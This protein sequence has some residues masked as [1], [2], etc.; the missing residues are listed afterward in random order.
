MSSQ[1]FFASANGPTNRS[2]NCALIGKK[3]HK[4][5]RQKK[6]V[7]V[8]WLVDQ[9]KPHNLGSCTD[10]GT[11]RPYATLTN[12]NTLSRPLIGAKTSTNDTTCF[13]Q[14]KRVCLLV[15]DTEREQPYP[16]RDRNVLELLLCPI[17]LDQTNEKL[18]GRHEECIDWIGTERGSRNSDEEYTSSNCRALTR[19]HKI[20]DNEIGQRKTRFKDKRDT[21]VTLTN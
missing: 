13:G 6:S 18:I 5:T 19:R 9:H 12:K 1:N 16:R 20:T 15:T 10:R 2:S 8:G 21:A 17:W 14:H 3:K 7:L 11:N 4:N